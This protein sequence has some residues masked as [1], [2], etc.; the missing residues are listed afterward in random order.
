M[1]NKRFKFIDVLGIDDDGYLQY[2]HT[3]QST[4]E[5]G[6]TNQTITVN[7]AWPERLGKVSKKKKKRKKKTE[8]DSHPHNSAD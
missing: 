3:S 5:P 2:I 1:I 6:R 7:L 8:V 4:A